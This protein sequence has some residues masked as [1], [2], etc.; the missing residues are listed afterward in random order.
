MSLISPATRLLLSLSMLRGV[1]PAALKKASLLK[2]FSEQTIDQVANSVP[3]IARALSDR[4]SWDI[5]QDA[6]EKQVLEAEKHQARILSPMDAEYPRLLA[7]TKD[8]PFILYV[9]GSLATCPDKS[10]AIIG[11][12]EPTAHGVM[13]AERI[14]YF[15]AER[16]W[17]I[18]SG[19]AIG[20]DAIAHQAAL[21][22]GAH[23]VAV[24]AH[25]LHMIAPARHKKLAHDILA[26]GGAL[27]SE[28]PFGQNVQSQ[29]YVKRDR[30]QAGMAQGVVMIQSDV[31]GGS[32]HA[33][34]ASLNYG[35]WLAVP[36]PTDRDRGAGE[37]KIQANLVIAEG[38]ATE[39]ANL[40]HCLTD[41][42]ENVII[43]RSREDYFL[44]TSPHDSS[45]FVPASPH[46]H[47]ADD[48]PKHSI[49]EGT[50]AS[51]A[52]AVQDPVKESPVS[53]CTT[54]SR[55]EP[56]DDSGPYANHR[57]PT[58]SRVVVRGAPFANL[59]ITQL[60]PANSKHFRNAE[61]LLGAVTDL[62]VLASRLRYIQAR[63][64]VLHRIYSDYEHFR[65]DD[66]C[67]TV[68]F[69][70]EDL[71][72]QMKKAVEALLVV[73]N[74]K[75]RM[76]TISE[77]ANHAIGTEAQY[78]FD[79]L[80]AARQDIRHGCDLGETL[81]N[82]LDLRP[83]SIVLEAAQKDPA[84]SLSDQG[85]IDETANLYLDH[86]AQSLN[87]LIEESF[88]SDHGGSTT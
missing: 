75:I 55:E 80:N 29:Q 49:G 3:P 86:L 70:V 41:A 11:T 67:W 85:L 82:L 53:S 79:L 23:T 45:E 36:Y 31:K 69:A 54:E 78:Q 60:P 42:L 15:F 47:E 24:L 8:D 1:G 77:S 63:I 7:A 40:L 58:T 25:G 13:I 17:S 16:G 30:T 43:L 12:R 39:R 51:C 71:L 5:A 34:R 10:V 37:P 9:K 4:D 27:V 44:M 64:D 81:T 32:L 22:S 21:A 33:S 56:P 38:G 20:C 66:D 26:S 57:I 52:V 65:R 18:V 6:A 74:L 88:P 76:R 48:T 19:L 68:Q 2:G 84:S 73:R 83:L 62:T 35:R 50:D 87:D 59:N 72:A 14:A 61:R 46:T 28:Y